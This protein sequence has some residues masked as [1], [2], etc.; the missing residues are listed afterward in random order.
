M[1]DV[2]LKVMFS[3][4]FELSDNKMATVAEM[5][6]FRWGEIGE[7][8]KWCRPLR[9]WEEDQLRE[10][11]TCLNSKQD[12]EQSESN[13]YLSKTRNT[14]MSHKDDEQNNDLEFIMAGQQMSSVFDSCSIPS[15]SV[16][17]FKKYDVFLSFH[18]EDTRS[19]FSFDSCFVLNIQY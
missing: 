4:I 1:E 15:S 16:A 12:D 9:A 18:N 2:A 8:W 11:S 10:C 3:L 5:E 13:K 6:H 14:T 19:T 7:A 17:S